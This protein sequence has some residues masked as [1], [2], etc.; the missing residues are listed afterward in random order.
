MTCSA[1]AHEGLLISDLRGAVKRKRVGLEARVDIAAEV[2]VRDSQLN[3]DCRTLRPWQLP[4]G[5]KGIDEAK[6]VACSSPS[7]RLRDAMPST[8]R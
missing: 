7:C 5:P 6:K 3:W 1:Q 8:W 2:G 4:A